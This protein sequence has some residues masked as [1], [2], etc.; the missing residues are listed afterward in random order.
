MSTAPRTALITTT[1]YEPRVL[2][3]YLA[4]ARQYGHRLLLVVAGDRK[5]PPVGQHHTHA[6]KAHGCQQRSVELKQNSELII[7]GK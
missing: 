4:N 3:A 2:L 7:C 1:I 5:T 6:R